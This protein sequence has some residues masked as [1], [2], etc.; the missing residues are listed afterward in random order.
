MISGQSVG[1]SH[2][3]GERASRRRTHGT[4]GV[5]ATSRAT[6]NAA[7]SVQLDVGREVGAQ[8]DGVTGFFL[9]FQGEL[10]RSGI[11]LAEVVD[12]RIGLGRG[13]S[14]HEVRNRDSCQEADDRDNDHDFYQGEARLTDVFG[15]FHFSFLSCW[16]YGG[17][18]QQAGL[19]DY[20]FVPLIACC[21]RIWA[22][23]SNVNANVYN[24]YSQAIHKRRIY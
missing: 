21:N 24:N 14:A 15:L 3:A 8:G 19:Y 12:A 10:I 9:V 17:T 7:G 2:R 1:R 4:A 11:N 16:F 22:T 20:D 18:K 5:S 23:L 6:R 13:T